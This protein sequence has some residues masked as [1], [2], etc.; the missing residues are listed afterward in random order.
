MKK[1][2]LKKEKA[3]CQSAV[4]GSLPDLKCSDIQI[5]N[6]IT[7]VKMDLE[8]NCYDELDNY[9]G[10]GILEGGTLKITQEVRANYL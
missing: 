3:Y 6:R 5:P 2:K 8:G 7:K 10:K 1:A 4:I 9:L